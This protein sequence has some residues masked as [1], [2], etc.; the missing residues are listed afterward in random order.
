MDT[1]AWIAIAAFIPCLVIELRDRR[2][3]RAERGYFPMTPNP[4]YPLRTWARH[5]LATFTDL[6]RKVGENLDADTER[7]LNEFR[8]KEG[9]DSE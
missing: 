1:L 4:K 9:E 6:R 7:Y 8:T 5:P 3:Y 2:K